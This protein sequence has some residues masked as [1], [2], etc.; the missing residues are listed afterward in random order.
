MD[1][2]QLIKDAAVAMGV[3]QIDDYNINPTK[4]ADALE[5]SAPALSKILRGSRLGTAA[6]QYEEKDLAATEAQ[7][8]FERV[9]RRANCAVFLSTCFSAALLMVPSLVPGSKW[10]LVTLGCCGILSGALGAMWLFEIRQGNLL[11]AWMTGRARAETERL[12][13]FELATQSVENSQSAGIPLPLLQLE[14]FRRYQLDVQ[15]AYYK[16]RRR[17]HK[18]TADKFL[19]LGAYA[20]GLGALATGFGGILGGALDSKWACLAG[21]ATVASALSAFASTNEA[22]GQN[23]R[24][25]ELYGKTNDALAELAAK[26]DEVRA[27]AAKGDRESLKQFVAAVHEQLSIEHKQWL[28][29]SVN[30]AAS[31][32][33]LDQALTEAKSKPAK[34]VQPASLPAAPTE[35]KAA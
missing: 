8:T 14:Y 27:A 35:T 22:L 5:T 23:R 25:Q 4:H 19:T 20:V 2:E 9:A 28:D 18:K 29:A 11:E 31:L 7:R 32:A 33:K 3:G 26:L 17:D 21:L 16:K 30:T 12:K 10:P 24:N 34:P 6:S 1:G 15:R 13:Y